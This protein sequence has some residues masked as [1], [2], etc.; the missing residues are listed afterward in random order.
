MT[1]D[2]Q[3]EL[4]FSIDSDIKDLEIM[5]EF[6]TSANY[7]NTIGDGFTL[8]EVEHKLKFQRAALRNI[9]TDLFII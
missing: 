1:N 8:K 3:D 4:I 9:T 6:L 2:E 7:S 5:L